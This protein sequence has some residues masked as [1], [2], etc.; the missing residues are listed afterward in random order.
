MS[1]T[2]DI[3]NNVTDYLEGDYEV[4]DAKVI[5]S[6]EDVTFGKVAKKMNLCV[7]YIDLRHST[8][9]LFLHNK[10]TAGKIHRSFLYT[11]STVI[12]HFNG[13]MRSFNGDSLLAFWPAFYK[14]EL[15]SCVRAA[16][17]VKWFL[18]L[19]L[20]PLFETYEKL[21]FGIGIDWGEVFIVRAGLPRDANIN[22]LVFMGRCVNFAVVI[23]QQAK[24]PYHVEISE[25]TYLNIEDAA[26]YGAM[27]DQKVDI[28][29]NGI[30]K[31]QEKE[32]KTKLTSWYWPL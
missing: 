26:I 28:W 27:N 6:V 15:T 20:S 1:I 25:I 11:V 14:S 21:D 30:V 19:E 18:D 10:Q 3:K 24:G 16:M 29:R 17:T 31:W 23:G 22:D 32:Y 5:P 2:D 9:L 7:F 8:D 13:Q 12:R 4:T